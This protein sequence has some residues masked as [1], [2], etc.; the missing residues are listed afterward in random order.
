MILAFSTSLTGTNATFTAGTATAGTPLTV[1]SNTQTSYTLQQF[2]TSSHGTN[3]AYFIAY[4]DG[5]GSQAGNFAMKNT[6]AGKNIFIEVDGASRLT[7]DASQALFANDVKANTHFTSSDTNVT[8]STNSDGTV[9]LRPNG[10]GST[11][12]QSTFTTALA[13]IGTNATFAGDLTV[14]GGDII[15]SGTGRIQGIDTVSS[16]TD[17]A[18]KTY[19]DNAISGVPQGTVT[20]TGVDNRLAI[21]NGTTAIDSDSDYFQQILKQVVK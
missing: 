15:L 20:G 8:L 2:K 6:L 7:I 21:W 5:H 10:K 3:N 13:S 9:F 17:A 14:E 1:G 12:A 11:T 19:V 16:G 4:G 18:N